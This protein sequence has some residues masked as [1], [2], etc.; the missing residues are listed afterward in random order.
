MRL[1]T[2]LAMFTWFRTLYALADAEALLRLRSV[3]KLPGP[4]K[5][6]RGTVKERGSFIRRNEF[7]RC[8]ARLRLPHWH[9]IVSALS[10][11]VASTITFCVFCE[12]H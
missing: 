12:D 5:E 8:K 1:A 7:A 6:L 11:G 2:G 3:L 4:R 10:V 9:S